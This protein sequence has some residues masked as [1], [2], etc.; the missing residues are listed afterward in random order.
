MLQIFFPH[1]FATVAEEN[2]KSYLPRLPNHPHNNALNIE[3]HVPGDFNRFVMAVTWH[4][5]YF[6]AFDPQPFDRLLPVQACN[7]DVFVQSFVLI[8]LI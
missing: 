5:L 3:L 6:P 1:N 7:H 8:V 4:E 2:K